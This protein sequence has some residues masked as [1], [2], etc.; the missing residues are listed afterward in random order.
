MLQLG[1]TLDGAYFGLLDGRWGAGSQ[2]AAEEVA[3]RTDPRSRADGIV[4]NYHGAAI[5]SRAIDFI[6][7]YDLSYRGSGAWQHRFL[8]PPGTFLED[9]STAAKDLALQYRG[10]EI[11]V[12]WCLT[13]TPVDISS[14]ST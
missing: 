11:N 13:N 2:E 9:A 12:F 8:S 4:R 5:A 6:T 1:L 3:A 7:E 10:I 14:H